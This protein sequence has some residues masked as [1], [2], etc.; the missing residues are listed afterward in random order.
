MR[1]SV[2][3]RPFPGPRDYFAGLYNLSQLPVSKDRAIKA[4]NSTS[5]GSFQTNMYHI[6]IKF[7]KIRILSSHRNSLLPV[8]LFLFLPTK[9]APLPDL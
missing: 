5:K 6:T 2:E 8:L 3:K 1:S 7:I 9:T 4:N